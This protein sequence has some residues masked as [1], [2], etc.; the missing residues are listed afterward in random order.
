MHKSK[1]KTACGEYMLRAFKNAGI[2]DSDDRPKAR[3][4]TAIGSFYNIWKDDFVNDHVNSGYFAVRREDNSLV[5]DPNDKEDVGIKGD[6]RREFLAKIFLRNKTKKINKIEF[7]LPSLTKEITKTSNITASLTKFIQVPIFTETDHNNEF[8]RFVSK[9]DDLDYEL[10]KDPRGFDIRDGKDDLFHV[11]RNI[12]EILAD[13]L[14][15]NQDALI[16]GPIKIGKTRLV[17]DVLR[18]T[19]ELKNSYVFSIYTNA[20]RNIDKLTV[21]D[22]FNQINKKKLFWLIDDLHYFKSIGEDLS[23]MYDKLTAKLGNII[24][25]ATLRSDE[26]INL[27]RFL[28][29]V[30]IIRVKPWSKKEGREYA[31]HYNIPKDIIRERF[32]VTVFSLINDIEDMKRRYSNADKSNVVNNNCRYVLR[33]LKLLSKF[34]QF[35][36]YEILERTFLYLRNLK[37]ETSYFENSIKILESSGFIETT[38]RYVLSWEPYLKDIVT[39]KDYRNLNQDIE[40]IMTLF[41]DLHKHDELHLLSCYFYNNYNF[42]ACANCNKLIVDSFQ[43]TDNHHIKVTALINW[44]ITLFALGAKT[45]K[46][47]IATCKMYYEESCSKYEEAA[48]YNKKLPDIYMNWGNSLLGL[49]LLHNNDVQYKKS[50][51]KY[52]QALKYRENYMEA[53]YNWGLA[54][55][56]FANKKNDKKLHNEAHSKSELAEI[57]RERYANTYYE[58]SIT[59]NKYRKLNNKGTNVELILDLFFTSFLMSILQHNY[60]ISNLAHDE[61]RRIG[62]EI[63]TEKY[64][65]IIDVFMISLKYKNEYGKLSYKELHKLELYKGVMKET[66]IVIDAICERKKPKGIY[67]PNA[68]LVLKTALFL[69]NKIVEIQ[70][71]KMKS[72]PDLRSW[73]NSISFSN[74]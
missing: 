56:S 27:P 17:F 9:T 66:D 30:K 47:N 49:A 32:S 60:Q 55:S 14:K 7:W 34:M 12:N 6:S 43:Q 74:D 71:D 61:V 58:L 37:R 15:I 73:T 36:D 1:T 54:L 21:S 53:Y 44:G 52:R 72:K 2:D 65:P 42:E 5:G 59:L 68:K 51:L 64:K 38:E 3:R 31:N 13:S 35:V 19:K 23:V 10:L 67:S 41:Y 25:V 33:Y 8:V 22:D 69:A 4:I 11:E 39:S 70:K 24:V 26:R 20:L 29:N 62:K 40:R 50:F 48:K 46:D 57:H 45:E 63:N 16:E 28:K 18:L